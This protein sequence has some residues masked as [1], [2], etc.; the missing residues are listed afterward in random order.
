MK[1][2]S[3]VKT[4]DKGEILKISVANQSETGESIFQENT[5]NYT[6]LLRD[7]IKTSGFFK[8]HFRT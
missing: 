2:T 4:N 1:S 8:L 7:P 5:M 6:E 3:R